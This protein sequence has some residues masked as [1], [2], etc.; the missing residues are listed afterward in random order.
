M[1]L[2]QFA[3]GYGNPF[4]LTYTPPPPKPDP[5][6][7]DQGVFTSN[8]TGAPPQLWRAEVAVVSDTGRHANGP[9][10]VK[11]LG[12]GRTAED[13]LDDL[14]MQLAGRANTRL[15]RAQDEVA[16]KAVEA[17]ALAKLAGGGS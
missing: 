2:E 3:A 10:C 1:K 17:A 16:E 13:A 6:T 12:A 8:Q 11:I 4:T 7:A 14:V 9:L 5:R 15:K